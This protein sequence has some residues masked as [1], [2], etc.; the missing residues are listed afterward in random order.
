MIH[1]NI[2]EARLIEVSIVNLEK[3]RNVNPV[4]P[5]FLP[6]LM[7]IS[8]LCTIVC[9]MILEWIILSVIIL[10][11]KLFTKLYM[12]GSKKPHESWDR[13]GACWSWG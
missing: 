3:Y 1:S 6:P 9:E 5:T 8:R 2:L 4:S 13:G 11:P 7:C 10:Q 12:L